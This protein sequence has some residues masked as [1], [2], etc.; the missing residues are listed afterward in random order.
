MAEDGKNKVDQL[1]QRYIVYQL[2][3]DAF[4]AAA[5]AALIWSF[6]YTLYALSWI[7][8]V[9]IFLLIYGFGLLL[10]RWW[11]VGT[12]PI[13]TFLDLKYPDLEESSGLVLK[14]SS[15]LNPLEKMQLAH[16][17]DIL[18]SVPLTQKQFA[19]RLR[20]GILFFLV[21]PIFCWEITWLHNDWRIGKLKQNTSIVRSLKNN[22][23]EKVLPQVNAVTI[24]ISPPAYTR[25]AW[26]EQDKFT[27]EAEEGSMTAWRLSLNVQAKTVELIFN[28]GDKLSLRK[29]A[30]YDYEGQR[31]I[32]KSGFYQVSID[33]KLSDL[34]QLQAIKDNPPVIHIKTPQQ[35]TYI[36]AGEVPRVTINAALD[37]DYGIRNAFI[38]T[39]L[40]KGSGEAVKFKEQKID[41]GASFSGQNP[42]YDL[43]KMISLPPLGMQPGDEL[44]FYVQAQDNYNQLSR[45]DVYVVSLQD[46][47]QLLSMDGLIGGVSVK[48]E[49]FRSERQII[50][51]S[52]KL[53]RDKDSTSKE[54]FNTRSNDLGNDQK[55]LRL[56]YGKFLG[57]EAESD[58]NPK[59]EQND[60]VSDP[61]NFGNA[62]VVLDKYSDK[63]DNA[64]D[65]QF[66]DP[67]VKAQLK[68]TLTEMWKAELQLRLYKPEAALPFE[69]KALRLL[70]DLQQKSRVYVAKTAYNPAPLKMEKRL[71]GDLSKIIQP[72]DHQIVKPG[73]DEYR[74][75]KNAV[76]VLESLRYEKIS[77]NVYIH[78]LQLANQQLSERAS[79]QPEL[80]LAAVSALRKIISTG[81]AKKTDISTVE[82][83]IHRLLP[84]G[85]L[86]PS[87]SQ[88]AVDMG[89][90]SGYYKN[91]DN[92]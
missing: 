17:E 12:R 80:Y 6:G 35:Y 22:I 43:Q 41:F 54:A 33:G 16:V 67:G 77:S 92:K 8:G 53:L 65:A 76:G 18:E 58:I 45:S 63:H 37:D 38:Y 34:Y 50:L 64:E 74:A 29:A 21:M 71:T 68:A 52:E 13:I 20:L 11:E 31:R 32:T 28:N 85:K 55:I 79:A 59:E 86:L 23:V 60:A 90:S 62:A 81:R 61:K 27:I 39:T 9:L 44:Y 91:L 69:Y 2:L 87:A 70:K 36:D 14:E 24:K 1:R 46:T 48:P 49:F 83:A 26:R 66:F 88:N 40:A 5:L 84:V 72:T 25:K 10:S 3:A 82:K 47:A 51:D 89:L 78:T 56:R 73:S 4:F 7:W 15:T 75:L 57:E 19:Y 42:H 30:G